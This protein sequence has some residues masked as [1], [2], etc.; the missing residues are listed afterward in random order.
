M[1]FCVSLL[2]DAASAVMAGGR[3]APGV[4]VAKVDSLGRR[5]LLLGGVSAMVVALLVLGAAELLLSGRTESLTSVAA[6]LLY[7]GAYQVAR[8]SLHDVTMGTLK[9]VSGMGCVSWSSA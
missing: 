4:A 1:P 9:L 6:L 8:K 5:P 7:V 2:L 3:C